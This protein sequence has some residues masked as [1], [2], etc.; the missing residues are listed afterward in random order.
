MLTPRHS[1]FRVPTFDP[2]SLPPLPAKKADNTQQPQQRPALRASASSSNVPATKLSQR[3]PV[4]MPPI[5]PPRREI[6]PVPPPR[7][8]RESG[9]TAQEPEEEQKPSLPSRPNPRQVKA[10]P[11]ARRSALSYGMNKEE[12]PPPVPVARPKASASPPPIPTASRPNLAAIQASKPKPP[13]VGSKQTTTAP[14]GCCLKC[15]DFS[16][17]DE[18]AAKFPRESNPHDINWLAEVS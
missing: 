8:R 10:P 11:P 16:G 1:T 14:E 15:R 12:T 5:P 18:H 3:P 9:Q 17:P 2:S 13:F 4:D 6:S 7:P